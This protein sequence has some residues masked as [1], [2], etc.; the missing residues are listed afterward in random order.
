MPWDLG[1]VA[2]QKFSPGIDV[3]HLIKWT[4]INQGGKKNWRD[5]E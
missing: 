2:I 1:K 5:Q 4:E 3:D